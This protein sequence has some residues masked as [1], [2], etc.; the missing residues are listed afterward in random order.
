MV[1]LCSTVSH[2]DDQM[3]LSVGPIEKVPSENGQSF[4]SKR[5]KTRK[6]ETKIKKSERMHTIV[7]TSLNIFFKIL[8]I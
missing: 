6:W 2:I 3:F 4:K 8:L 1:C 7:K 5:V